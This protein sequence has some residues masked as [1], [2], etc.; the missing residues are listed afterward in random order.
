M[1]YRTRVY[2]RPKKANDGGGSSKKQKSSK[3]RVNTGVT[4]KKKP[5][6]NIDELTTIKTNMEA[7]DDDSDELDVEQGESEDTTVSNTTFELNDSN[8][9]PNTQKTSGYVVNP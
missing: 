1:C 5:K 7:N 6:K 2:K 4:V 8:E 9:T 3:I